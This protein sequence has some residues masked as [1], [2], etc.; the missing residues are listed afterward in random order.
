MKGITVFLWFDGQAEEAADFYTS[1]FP[2]SKVTDVARY[3]EVGPG[4]PGAV[5]TVAFELDGRKFV[6]LNGGPQFTFN[7][8][9]SFAINCETQAEVDEYWERLGEGGEHGPCGWLKDRYGVSWQVVPTA[10][11][12]LLAQPDREAAQRVMATMLTMSKLDVEPLRRA[13]EGRE[14]VESAS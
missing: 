1:L 7:E 9:V 3:G 11:P 8:A 12:E 14:P 10:L 5:M 2:N 4:E 6:G 13:A